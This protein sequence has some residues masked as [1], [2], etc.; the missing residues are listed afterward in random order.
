MNLQ[1]LKTN[2]QK[3]L[4]KPLTKWNEKIDIITKYQDM[5]KG[6]YGGSKP[7]DDLGSGVGDRQEMAKVIRDYDINIK[8]GDDIH[9]ILLETK[10]FLKKLF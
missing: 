8:E 1:T 6:Q 7:C 5:K 9:K 10:I 2:N 4:F 3:K